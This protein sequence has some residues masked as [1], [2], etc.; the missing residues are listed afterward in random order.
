MNGD[1]PERGATLS[2]EKRFDPWLAVA[3]SAYVGFVVL[4]LALLIRSALHAQ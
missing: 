1:S 3:V 2:K 4:M